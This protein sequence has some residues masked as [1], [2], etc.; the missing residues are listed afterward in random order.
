MI[1]SCYIDE[2]DEAATYT[3]VLDRI[4]AQAAPPERTVTFLR[5][6]GKEI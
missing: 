4:C 1:S 2:P 6:I 5:D 3:K